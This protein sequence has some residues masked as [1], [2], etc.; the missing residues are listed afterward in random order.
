[1]KNETTSKRKIMRY[2]GQYVVKYKWNFC[3]TIVGITIGVITGNV[4]QLVYRE[5]ID[6]IAAFQGED[7]MALFPEI[8]RW[9]YILAVVLVLQEVG[10]RLA[11]FSNNYF[12]SSAMRDIEQDCYEK[13]QKHSIGF[14][15]NHF[16]G[17]LVS[18]A[19]RLVYGFERIMDLLYWEFY[20]TILEFVITIVIL[21]TIAPIFGW[22]I[23][24]WGI[25]FMAISYKFSLWKMK[26]D[27]RN[28]SMDSKVT[29][30]MA[31]GLTNFFNVKSFARFPFEKKR[32]NNISQDRYVIRKWVWNLGTA[33]EIFQGCFM[34]LLMIALLYFG[35]R[36]W[37]TGEITVGSLVL[38]NTISLNLLHKLWNFGRQVKD[39]IEGFANCEEMIQIVYLENEIKDPKN[40]EK[41][42]I[43]KG[44]I[45]FEKVEFAYEGHQKV[46]KD[47]NLSI[48]AGEKVGLVGES[49]SGKS[50]FTKLLLRFN[51]LDSGQIRIDDQ[52][53]TAITQ[54]D[55]RDQI[56]FVPQEAVLFHR[57]LIENIRYGDL[58]AS[59]EEVLKAAQRAHAHEFVKRT[60]KEYETLVGERGI[61]LS[62]GERQRIAI[63]RAMLKK[64]PILILDEATSSLDSKSEKLIQEALENL[65]E[66]RTTL[67]IAHRLS[68]IQ[69]MDRILV[70]DRGVI[71]EQGSHAEL[72]KK[73]GRYQELW[74]HQVAG[75]IE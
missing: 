18:K 31:D 10:W 59:D 50:T 41:C 4:I 3:L 13:A 67:V 5:I 32:F 2:F 12:Q 75:F 8:V 48:R 63:A 35:V 15:A 55:L 62:G 37:S 36:L 69:K 51:D 49:G 21:F 19:K 9:I 57:S 7:K 11:A 54:D 20:T 6:L 58:N 74:A 28:A 72:I 27:L 44:K 61:K 56:A 52:N 16:I 73:K 40:P 46:F 53:I 68:T 34:S 42:K 14:F 17:G 38:I 71:V 60:K 26:Y 65:M 23:L 25:I 1:M 33:F 24:V 30:E 22:I 47:F 29:A 66:S 43:R 70:F 45:E 64:A 39:L